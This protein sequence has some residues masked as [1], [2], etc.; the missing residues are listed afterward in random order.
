MTSETARSNQAV[1]STSQQILTYGG[2]PAITYF[3]S[4]SGGETENIENSFV[5]SAP[6]PWLKARPDP[7][8]G[9]SPKHRWQFR[10]S[11]SSIGAKLGVPGKFKKVS[12]I[13]RGKS[14]RIV[15]ARVYGSRG[16]RVLT[17]PQIRAR[18]GLYDSWAYFTGISTSP[19]K[20]AK[21]ARSAAASVFPELHGSFAPAPK[22]RSL[23]VER[24]VKGAWERVS[25]LTT[26][27]GGRYRT[28]LS[29]AGTYRVRAGNVAGPAVRIKG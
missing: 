19:V 15:R 24:R 8:D 12:V 18:L 21:G 26:T 4:S 25:Q 9:I 5:G 2:A 6:K 23:T 10:F 27:A 16:T 11:Q 3:F 22:G 29:T 14:P 17:G 1:A 20:K 7:Y 28:T 13:Q